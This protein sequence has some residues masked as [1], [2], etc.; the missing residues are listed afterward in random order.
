MP[1]TR[2]PLAAGDGVRRVSQC[3]DPEIRANREKTVGI[4]ALIQWL[5]Q[6]EGRGREHFS[7]RVA[8]VL[9]AGWV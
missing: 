6:S 4:A 5:P 1:A 3:R 9:V 8:F 7:T 2:K